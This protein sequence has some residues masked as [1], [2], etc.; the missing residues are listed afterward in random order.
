MHLW[1]F[2]PF[3]LLN[4]L[5]EA[6]YCSVYYVCEVSYNLFLYYLNHLY[7]QEQH[8]LFWEAAVFSL[9]PVF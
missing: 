6:E 9:L 3:F 2:L 5:S 8:Q 1:I 4:G 7:C